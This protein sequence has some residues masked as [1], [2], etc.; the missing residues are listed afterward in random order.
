MTGHFENGKWIEYRSE[1]RFV[2]LY[3]TA[4]GPSGIVKLIEDVPDTNTVAIVDS[5]IHTESS[6]THTASL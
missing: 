6:E 5:V 3:M 2:P 4:S 1:C